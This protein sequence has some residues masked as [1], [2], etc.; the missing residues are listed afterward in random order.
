MAIDFSKYKVTPSITTPTGSGG[1]PV[2][3]IDFSKYRTNPQNQIPTNPAPDTPVSPPESLGNRFMRSLTQLPGQ[4]A[5][6][7]PN[8]VQGGIGA[9]KAIAQPLVNTG[10]AIESGLDETLG[11]GINAMTG[12]GT[13]PTQSGAKGF[14]AATSPTLTPQG[15]E[16]KAG[17]VVGMIAPYLTPDAPAAA[18]ADA[19][20]AAGVLSK[21]GGVISKAA[22]G[23]AKDFGIATAQTKNAAQGLE[24]AVGGKVLEGAGAL[25]K[26]AGKGIF[27]AS[28]PVSATEAD[29]IQSYKAGES[30]I[31]R[32]TGLAKRSA[33]TTSGDTAFRTKG[34]MG[35]ESSIGV[36]ARRASQKLWKSVISPALERSTAKI[37]MPTFFDEAAASIRKNTPELGDQADRL[38][39]LESIKEDYK[40]TGIATAK[41]LQDFKKG[42]ASHV[43]NK[44][45]RG[46]DI[47]AAYNNVR[48]EL[49]GLA[50]QH[51]YKAVGDEAKQAYLD[52]GNMEGL[53]QLG[54]KAMTG[55]KLKGGSG[56]FLSGLTEKAL[57]PIATI[58]GKLLYKT[59]EGVQFAGAAGAK[60][61]HDI[62]NQIDNPQDQSSAPQESSS[63][64]VQQ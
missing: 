45:Y 24:V 44:A 39:A 56:A 60:S 64:E 48:N 27:K 15:T 10:S 42:W 50:R 35:L 6:E 33:P 21:L 16:E 4:A 12:K 62:L 30:L 26:G 37:D 13:A 11:R 38:K 29:A 31:S 36:Q 25:V 14:A 63:Q 52:Y 41:Q 22:P 9:I 40:Q 59:G 2:P 34:V 20:A 19:P 23:F 46:E 1:A 28:I 47:T 7:V 54:Q 32:I 58:G 49:A 53:Q 17:G 55:A 5:A 61:L 51:I 57:V 18:E 3:K 8:M 43:P